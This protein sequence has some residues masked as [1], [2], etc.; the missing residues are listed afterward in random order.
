MGFIKFI[1]NF[2]YATQ[3]SHPAIKSSKIKA[4]GPLLIKSFKVI[5]LKKNQ[6]FHAGICVTLTEMLILAN[7]AKKSNN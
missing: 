4:R 3:L 1:I 6:E 5:D 2:L 7:V